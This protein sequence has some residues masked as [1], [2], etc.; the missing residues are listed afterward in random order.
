MIVARGH[1]L[2]QD[3]HLAHY[4]SLQHAAVP[5]DGRQV[6]ARTALH[7]SGSELTFEAISC[8]A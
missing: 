2:F 7:Y 8:V 5:H 6:A 1:A 3:A 4:T